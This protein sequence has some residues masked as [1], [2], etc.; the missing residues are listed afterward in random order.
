MRDQNLKSLILALEGV[1]RRLDALE[2][3]LASPP[4][5]AYSIAPILTS[6]VDLMRAEGISEE[7]KA[8]VTDVRSRR[9]VGVPRDYKGPI[10]PHAL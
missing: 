8:Q 5:P 6:A 9:M 3:A 7:T 10:Y 4:A 1:N 2:K